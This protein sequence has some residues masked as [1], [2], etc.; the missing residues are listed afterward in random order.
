MSQ[1]KKRP[2]LEEIASEAGVSRSTVSRVVNDHPSVRTEVRQ[3]VQ[4]VIERMG[5]QPNAAARSLASSRSQMIGIVIP[6]AVNSL[7]VDPFF[8]TLLQGVSDGTAEHG[9]HLMLSMLGEKSQEEDFYRR[10]L[11]SQ[12]LDGLIISSAF[13]DDPLIARMHKESVPFVTVGRHADQPSISYVD[14]DNVNGARMAVDHLIEQGRRRIATI[15]G[16]LQ[17]SVG[18]DRLEG[19]QKALR[20]AGLPL[21]DS[22]AIE[23]DFTEMGGYTCMQ[24][25]MDAQPDAVFIASDLMAVGAMRALR[26][27]EWPVPDMVAVIGYDDAQIAAIADPPL[28]T[29]RQPIYQLGRMAVDSLIRLLTDEKVGPMHTILSTQLVIRD[30]SVS[31]HTP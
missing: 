13:L 1:D 30:S 24:H 25:L 11:R 16:P 9:Y 18:L 12:M 15:T 4:Q 20:K 21:D 29:V 6:R 14:V 7:F 2:T 19:Y 10:A 27:A 22:L 26:Q 8:P 31:T 3:R 23:G 5:Y 17:T 28:T